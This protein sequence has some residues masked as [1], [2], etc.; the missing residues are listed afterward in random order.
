MLAKT[1]TKFYF[2]DN[3]AND[4]H[5]LTEF[6]TIYMPTKIITL[7]TSDNITTNITKMKIKIDTYEMIKSSTKHTNGTN[8][9]ALFCN[10]HLP[11][12]KTFFMYYL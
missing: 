3:P 2:I 12:D 5:L 8:N 1:S 6:R 7:F 9:T 4:T 10:L 11:R